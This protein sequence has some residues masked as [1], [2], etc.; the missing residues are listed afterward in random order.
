MTIVA[1]IV[2]LALF[3]AAC[4]ALPVKFASQ[5]GHVSPRVMRAKTACWPHSGPPEP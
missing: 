3:G 1:I 2:G 5:D 4:L